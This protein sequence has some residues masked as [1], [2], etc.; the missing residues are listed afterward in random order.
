MTKLRYW[1]IRKIAGKM[2]VVL[3]TKI[4]TFGEYGIY[5]DD[6]TRGAL[7]ADCEVQVFPRVLGM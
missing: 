6:G 4:Q 2:P 7:I 5:L 3:N 1:L